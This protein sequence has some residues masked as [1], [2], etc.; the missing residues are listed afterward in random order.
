MAE[1]TKIDIIEN[2]KAALADALIKAAEKVATEKAKADKPSIFQYINTVILTLLGIISMM[3][4]TTLRE[5]KAKQV[6]TAV[7]LVRIKTIQ[8]NSTLS[9]SNL[10]ARV[11]AIEI[12]RLDEIKQW[13]EDN[14]IRKIK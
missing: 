9:I 8:D 4:F 12:N 14:F 1:E 7:E 3:T 2:E 13:T 10:N 11:S 5:V 6:E